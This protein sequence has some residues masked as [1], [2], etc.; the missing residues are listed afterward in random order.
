M[1]SN[2][3]KVKQ[4]PEEIYYKIL[5]N[6]ASISNLIIFNGDKREEILKIDLIIKQDANALQEKYSKK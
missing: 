2:T 6:I 1:E 5:K 3:V 4:K